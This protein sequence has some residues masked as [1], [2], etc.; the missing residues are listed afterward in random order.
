M[1]KILLAALSITVIMLVAWLG[2]NFFGW[3]SR[4]SN[5]PEETKRIIQEYIETNYSYDELPLA[6]ENLGSYALRDPQLFAA[7]VY[8]T[9]TGP[10]IGSV[11][12]T[13]IDGL[14]RSIGYSSVN[15]I[16]EKVFTIFVQTTVKLMELYPQ[17]KEKYS[18]TSYLQHSQSSCR[19][20]LVSFKGLC[21]RKN[22]PYILIRVTLGKYG[23]DIDKQLNEWASKDP[24]WSLLQ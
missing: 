4:P 15:G 1:K 6:N 18:I 22:N 7:L 10:N 23:D 12:E 16:D 5:D 11:T 3:K 8:E 2:L 21:L 13:K 14:L 20:E 19:G 24:E 9:V 17:N